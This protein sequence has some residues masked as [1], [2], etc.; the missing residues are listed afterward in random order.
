M[1]EW[2]E[3]KGG[4]CPV[5]PEAKV[6][7][8]FRNGQEFGCGD[9][10][11]DWSV[12]GGI[13]AYRVVKEAPQPDTPNFTTRITEA[14]E[15]ALEAL[16]AIHSELHELERQFQTAAERHVSDAMFA[17]MNDLIVLRIAVVTAAAL[18]R[19]YAGREG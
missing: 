10:D 3:W 12:H 2:I 16:S 1:S 8:R 15:K 5:P 9:A 17:A 6:G 4:Q 11:L 18:A 14:E 7:V 13:V 19:D